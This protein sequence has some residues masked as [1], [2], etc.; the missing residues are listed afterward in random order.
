MSHGQRARTPAQFPRMK[1]RAA[2]RLRRQ[3]IRLAQWAELTLP[4][5]VEL[6]KAAKA[7]DYLITQLRLLD[8]HRRPDKNIA[9]PS[10]DSIHESLRRIG[11][12]PGRRV[13]IISE[14]TGLSVEEI[15]R[16]GG[17]P[18]D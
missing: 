17:V 16:L 3:E 2:G 10:P 5:P 6:G 8:F 4:N 12:E 14:L 7:I 18:D 15:N 13:R 9:E 1:H 11:N